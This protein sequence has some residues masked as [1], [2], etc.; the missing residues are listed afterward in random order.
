MSGQTE[1]LMWTDK[2][3][4]QPKWLEERQLALYTLAPSGRQINL[5]SISMT[6]LKE[7][8]RHTCESLNMQLHLSLQTWTTQKPPASVQV[9]VTNAILPKGINLQKSSLLSAR[10]VS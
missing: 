4:N 3:Q 8:A 2:E 5:H 1:T 9:H 7:T 6:S 10:Q